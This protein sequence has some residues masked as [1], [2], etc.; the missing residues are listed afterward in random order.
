MTSATP[1]AVPTAPCHD[2]QRGRLAGLGLPRSPTT[3]T[4]SRS[5]TKPAAPP[6]ANLRQSLQLRA[7]VRER[8]PTPCARPR[9][10]L[11]RASRLTH[12]AKDAVVSDQVAA[13]QA[14]T[15]EL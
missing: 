2:Q 10:S 7:Q 12:G 14:T 6:S 11:Q 9:Q 4:L 5:S 13:D 3:S 15:P 1:Q 8:H